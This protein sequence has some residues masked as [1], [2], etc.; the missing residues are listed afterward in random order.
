MTIETK[1]NI[2]IYFFGQSY[3]IEIKIAPHCRK[4]ERIVSREEMRKTT[5]AVTAE[6]FS[7][8][9]L[10]NSRSDSKIAQY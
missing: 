6:G 7:S 10:L 2:C 5:T 9:H 4:T 8:L 3:R 1:Y